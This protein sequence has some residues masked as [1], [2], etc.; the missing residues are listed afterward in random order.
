[1]DG[2]V[3][4]HRLA[5][6]VAVHDHHP[7]ERAEALSPHVQRR[8]RLGAERL[9]LQREQVVQ[10][11]DRGRVVLSSQTGGHAEAPSKYA[12]GVVDEHRV[13]LLLRH[14]LLEQVRQ[15]PLVDVRVL[16][17]RQQR[18]EV[19][20]DPVEVAGGVLRQ[21]HALGV[22]AAAQLHDDVGAGLEG[23]LQ[24]DAEAVHPEHEPASASSDRWSASV[25]SPLWPEHDPSRVDPLLART[26]CTASPC[27]EPGCVCTVIGVPV[28]LCASATARMTRSTPGVMPWWSMAHLSSPALTEVPAM[29]SRMSPTNMSTIGSGPRSRARR[30]ARAP[31]VEVE[32]HLVVGV[33]A[34]RAH[35]VEVDLLG[36][37]GD[38]RQV[39]AEPTTVGST[40]VRTPRAATSLSLPTAVRDPLLLRPPLLRVDSAA[41]PA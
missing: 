3:G 26:F 25:L 14:A 35:D 37:L 13:D 38:A 16:P 23:G 9:L 4:A 39:T 19:L 28:S 12:A 27:C 24:V 5:D 17:V 15:H 31:V 32:R 2:E 30:S 22:A 11:G 20:L 1:V 10:L 8:V 18:H 33:E 40:I 41:R 29:P 34:G 21:H 6:A 36:D 7:G